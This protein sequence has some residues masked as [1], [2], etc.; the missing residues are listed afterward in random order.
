[1]KAKRS[2]QNLQWALIASLAAI[3]LI[4]ISCA[5][6][7]ED[8]LPPP[9]AVRCETS[10]PLLSAD[11]SPIIQQN[12]AV[13]GCHVSGTGR[14]DFTIKDNIL[15]YAS[16]IMA[17]TQSGFMPPAGSG[18]SIT[19]TQKELIYCWVTKGAQDN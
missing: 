15:Q 19:A 6:E 5:S 17:N 2:S 3:L 14:A 7:S 16:T 1:M 4:S 13:A 12:C 18:R 8:Q 10:N 11:V 9:S